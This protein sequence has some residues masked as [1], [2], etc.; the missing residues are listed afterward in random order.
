MSGPLHGQPDALPADVA[1]YRRTP[2]FTE[3]TLP[4]GLR[5]DHSTKAGVWA[6]IHVLEG[7]LRYCVPDWHYDEILEPGR[8]GIVAPEVLHFVEPEG[9][10]RMYVEFHARPERAP[11]DPHGVRQGDL[12]D[13]PEPH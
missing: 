5:R 6:L 9:S 3:R 1:P 13:H 7:R 2:D 12:P 11:A 10:V 8:V 4:A